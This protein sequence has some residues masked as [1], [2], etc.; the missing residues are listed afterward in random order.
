ME[1]SD[2]AEA[3]EEAPPGFLYTKCFCEENTYK[4]IEQLVRDAVCPVDDLYAV[5][6]SS[7]R[8]QFPILKQRAGDGDVIV[9]DYHVLCVQ[10]G[11]RGAVVW[12]LDTV[13]RPFPA[14][15]ELYGKEALLLT[16][17]QLRAF[18]RRFRVVAA[19]SFLD[20]FSSDRRHMRAADGSWT[21]PPPAWD[22]LQGPRARAAGGDAPP[23]HRLP[24]YIDVSWED[25]AGRSGQPAAL[26]EVVGCALGRVV[27]ER[28]LWELFRGGRSDA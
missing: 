11:A 2:A 1:V 6:L 16:A 28:G 14:P 21:M 24:L 15:F 13:L 22:V 20:C 12:D 19:R 27:D 9:W 10:R 17:P 8:R 3:S 26:Q 18:D 7:P 5:F 25:D 23:E 4:L